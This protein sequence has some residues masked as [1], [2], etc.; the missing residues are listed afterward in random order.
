[1]SN[2]EIALNG[3]RKRE[4]RVASGADRGDCFRERWRHCGTIADHLGGDYTT[5]RLM[6]WSAAQ[7]EAAI[8]DKADAEAKA[9]AKVKD[10]QKKRKEK[11]H[12]GR[13]HQRAR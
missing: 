9:A 10:E 12:K 1:M 13:N 7:I 6:N 11:R 5:S 4:A 3:L 8:L 2:V